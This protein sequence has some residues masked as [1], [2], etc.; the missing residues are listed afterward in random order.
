M[1]EIHN[2]IQLA[3]GDYEYLQAFVCPAAERN[4]H[5]AKANEYYR[6]SRHLA[7]LS[8]LRY[9]VDRSL[10]VPS[11][12]PGFSIDRSGE[13][14]PLEDLTLEQAEEVLKKETVLKTLSKNTYVN[15]DRYEFDRFVDHSTAREAEIKKALGSNSKNETSKPS[16]E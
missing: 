9:Y 11:L 3:N 8:L 5:L 4:D 13:H 16:N 7:Y 14:R 12:P 10:V 2:E 6:E 15:T 1:E